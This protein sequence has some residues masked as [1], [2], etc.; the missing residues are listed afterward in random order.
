MAARTTI[1]QRSLEAWIRREFTSRARRALAIYRRVPLVRDDPDYPF[2]QRPED[3]SIRSAR[4]HS[5]RRIPGGVRIQVQS[6]GAPFFE[7]GNDARGSEIT[8]RLALPLKGNARGARRARGNKRGKA[9]RV[10][11]DP[12]TG[13]AYLMVQRVRTYRGRH[14]LERSVREAFGVR[15]GRRA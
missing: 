5:I 7:G 1:D 10:I 8:G 6:R 11:I 4:A 13:R 3:G 2:A 9:G 15:G 12:N 14:A